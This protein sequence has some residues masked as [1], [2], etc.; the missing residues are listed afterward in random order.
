MLSYLFPREV[1]ALPPSSAPYAKSSKKFR[2]AD[3]PFVIYRMG[4]HALRRWTCLTL[5]REQNFSN[6]PDLPR[7]AYIRGLFME[8]L[9]AR[10]A[11]DVTA[12]DGGAFL[13]GAF[14]LLDQI[15][16]AP[17]K[18]LLGEIGIPAP[19]WD[20]LLGNAENDCVRLLRFVTRCEAQAPDLDPAEI[21]TSLNNDEI[22]RLYQR[23]AEAA[24][25]AIVNMDTPPA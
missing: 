11:L 1:N 23:C 15:I 8:E 18:Y 22:G 16:G 3:M 5:M 19:V 24:D 25:A 10:S 9:A 17:P 7:R 20:A 21:Q 12:Q 4:P 13:C 14:S 2:P 6:D